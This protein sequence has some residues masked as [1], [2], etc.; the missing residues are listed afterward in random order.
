MLYRVFCPITG[1]ISYAGMIERW[2][3]LSNAKKVPYST[4]VFL[5]QD[6]SLHLPDIEAKRALKTENGVITSVPGS[7]LQASGTEYYKHHSTYYKHQ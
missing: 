6:S 1:L 3:L 4:I 2:G 5:A 7:D